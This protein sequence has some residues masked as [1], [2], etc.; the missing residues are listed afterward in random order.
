MD[1]FFISY[2]REDSADVTGRICEQLRKHFGTEAVFVDVDK[3][4]LG[5]DFRTTLDEKLNQCRVFLAVIGRS[6]LTVSTEDGERRL[7]QPNDFV[8]IEIETALARD[9]PVIPILVHGISMPPAE[10]LPKSL[11]PLAFRHAIAVRADPDFRHDIERLVSGLE[12]HV[13]KD[14]SVRA[15]GPESSPAAAESSDG[16]YQS[17]IAVLA[18]VLIAIEILL[19]IAFFLTDD[20]TPRTIG[21]VLISLLGVTLAAFGIRRGDGLAIG[22]GACAVLTPWVLR[23]FLSP[24]VTMAITVPATSFFAAIVVWRDRHILTRLIRSL[25]S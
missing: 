2:R 3:I 23:L 4:P 17:T 8:R 16:V 24:L 7:D 9:I 22:A 25:Q 19:L 14:S 11:R 21:V 18:G 12:R 13:S 1:H 6:W 15:Q 10:E 20:T 5:V